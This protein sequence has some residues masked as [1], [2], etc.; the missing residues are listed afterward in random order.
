M[1]KRLWLKSSIY[2]V[3]GGHW[4]TVHDELIDERGNRQERK[5]VAV[6]R[7]GEADEVRTVLRE[8]F[9]LAWESLRD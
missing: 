8:L 1:Y 4:L 5:L 3:P 2:R 6:Y 7:S 9:A